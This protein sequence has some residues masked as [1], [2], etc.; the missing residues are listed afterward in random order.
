MVT[1]GTCGAETIAGKRFCADCGAPVSGPSSGPLCGPASSGQR[2]QLTVLFCDV[3][4]S[5][6]VSAQLEPEDYRDVIRSYQQV[7]AEAI[8]RFEGYIAQYLG[9]GILAYFGYP[10]A[11][12]DDPH[13]AIR[14]GLTMIDRVGALLGSGH[15]GPFAI[16]VGIHTGLVVVGEMGSAGRLETLAM[17]DVPN[18]AA[19]V[20][21][22]A[23]PGEVLA[24]GTTARLVDGLFELEPRGRQQVKGLTS[25]IDVHRVVAERARSRFD[26]PIPTGIQPL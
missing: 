6:A 24:T 17:G 4:G 16:R 10:V 19:R 26:L 18:V 11:H 3:V 2:R 21:G 7:V 9:D 5:T 23:S 1:C 15:S 13:R 22:L 20:Q 25:A 8:E 14:A 12:E